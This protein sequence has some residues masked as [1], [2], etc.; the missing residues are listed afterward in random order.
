MIQTN[1]VFIPIPRRRNN[2]CYVTI[3]GQDMTSRVVDSW[4]SKPCTNGVGTFYIKLSNAGGQYSDSFTSGDKVFFQAN[5]SDGETVQFSGIIDYPNENISDN[6]QFL[7][8][9]GRHVSY[10]VNEYKI[11]Y[12]AENKDTSEILKDII[13]LM[14]SSYGITYT[15]VET[16]NIN[17]SVEW[18]YANFW[19]CVIEIANKAGFDCYIDDD[20]D[21]HYF[22]ENSISNTTN[23]ISEGYNFIK[24]ENI[25]TNNY[26]KRTRVIATGQDKNGLPIIYTAIADNEGDDIREYYETD[27]SKDTYEKVKNLAESK[28]EELSNRYL[29]AKIV[30]YG[31]QSI[32]PG[33]NIWILVPRQKIA[34]QYK[35]VNITHQFGMKTGGWRTV[36]NF[37]EHESSVADAVSYLNT[38]TDKISTIQNVN[39]MNYSYNF[40]FSEDI[41]SHNNTK[42]DIYKGLLKTNG[43]SSGTWESPTLT[44][45]ENV[46]ALELR[47]NAEQE[48]YINVYVSLNGGTTWSPLNRINYSYS[49]PTGKNIKIKVAFSSASAS[50]SSLALLYS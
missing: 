33:D 18:N 28:L 19:D 6:G 8:I 50:V 31:L 25:G 1:R 12:S 30:S 13:D 20:L 14:P 16:S 9:E 40:D 5:N 17:M 44:V 22:A 38:K 36:T 23:Y 47:M 41:G 15:N 21:V 3:A 4:W 39:K 37:E 45:E 2:K 27:A 34:G 35:L 46:S 32:N 10:K 29:E 49:L 7:E 11:C 42:I 48:S 43:T 24:S 26:S